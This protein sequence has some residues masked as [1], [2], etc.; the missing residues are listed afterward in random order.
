MRYAVQHKK[1]R[2]FQAHLFFFMLVNT[3]LVA[4]WAAAGA[5]RFWPI[6]PIVGWGILLAMH[7]RAVYKLDEPDEQRITREMERE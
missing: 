1:E 2:N 7:G 3:F 4:T 6:L 5:H